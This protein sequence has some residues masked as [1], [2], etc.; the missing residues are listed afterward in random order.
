MKR[1][2]LS[3]L[4]ILLVSPLRADAFFL[5]CGTAAAAI[6]NGT[7]QQQGLA[8]GHGTGTIDMLTALSCFVGRPNCECL[9]RLLIDSPSAYSEAIGQEL[10]SCAVRSP[11]DSAVGPALRAAARLC[12]S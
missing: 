12:G 3:S 11:N 4:A 1:L 8:I 6:L 2:V 5:S 10:A 9:D 7:A